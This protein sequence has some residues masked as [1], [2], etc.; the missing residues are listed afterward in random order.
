MRIFQDYKRSW[1][2]KYTPRCNFR[3]LLSSPSGHFFKKI[4][5]AE[6]S[7]HLYSSPCLFAKKM[8]I[9]LMLTLEM[10]WGPLTRLRNSRWHECAH[11][12]HDAKFRTVEPETVLA[13]LF[14][15][16]LKVW[17]WL[18]SYFLVKMKAFWWIGQNCSCHFAQKL[19]EKKPQL[20]IVNT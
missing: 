10:F 3:A 2:K 14:Y 17:I 5:L 7:V 19:K 6:Y 11:L 8:P 4:K 12:L 18:N 20:L 1:S 13:S 9:S 15:L 16:F